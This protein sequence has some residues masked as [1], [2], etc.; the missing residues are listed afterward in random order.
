MS[1]LHGTSF[2]LS[3]CCCTRMLVCFYKKFAGAPDV[4]GLFGVTDST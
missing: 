4:A 3:K 1:L 2:P